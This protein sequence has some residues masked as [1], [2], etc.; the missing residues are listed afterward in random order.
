M[1]I[2]SFLPSATETLYALG[3]G[4]SVVG[5][6]YECD[7]PPEVTSKP[8]VVHTK[9]PHTSSP[10]EIDRLVNE[11]VA[12]GE[13]LYRV[14]AELL[15][16][17]QPDLIVTQNLCHVCAASPDDL[18][19][20]LKTLPGP[21]RVVSLNPHTIAEVLDDILRLGEATGQLKQAREL[22]SVL[23]QRIAAVKSAVAGAPRPRVLCLEWLDPP[24][25]A[26]HWVPEMVD[27]A[28]G[29]DVL[30]RVGRP[31][32]RVE[33]EEVTRSEADIAVLM[34]CGYDLQQTLDEFAS[35]RLPE[36]WH[37]LPAAQR[38]QVFAVDATSYCS[39]HGPRVVTGIEI[40]A[41]LFHPEAVSMP[42]P[43]KSVANV[44][45]ARTAREG[46]RM[47]EESGPAPAG[48]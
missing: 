3:L 25:A 30:G 16:R 23:R 18:S 45:E 7:F 28:G 32:F 10:A 42:L 6:T 47:S 21:P 44:L 26:G 22:A 39:R 4:D 24:F 12:R 5:V 20:A 40:L 27:L 48:F 19:S 46:A 37:D 9:L 1:R 43:P 13:S 33:W 15:Q 17:L 11:F 35:L 14:D 29:T 31:S 8:V 34:P 41:C 38:S 2:C 36:R